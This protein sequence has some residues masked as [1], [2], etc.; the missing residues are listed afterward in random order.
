MSDVL[1]PHPV[2]IHPPVLARWERSPSGVAY[3]QERDSG[4]D[5]PQVLLTAL[6]HGNEFAG[7]I[8]LDEWLAR[9]SQ[10]RRG[11]ITVAFCNVAAFGRFDAAAPDASRFTDEDFNRVW[12]PERLDGPGQSAELR[13]ARELRP[14]VERCTHLLDLHSMHEPC[15]PLLVTG[16]RPRDI[17]FARALGCQGQIVID[18]GHADGV[19]MRDYEGQ[20]AHGN[21]R[22]A[23]LLEAG[24]HWAATSV[25]H[26]R[27]VLMRFLLAAGAIDPSDVV[28]G[29]L[30]PAAHETLAVRVTHRVVAQSK[31]FVFLDDFTGGEV[32][33]RAG[34]AIALDGGTP[35]RTPYDDCVLVMPSLRQLRP[36][37][38]T[39]RL[40]R[41][42]AG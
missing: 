42:S 15:H 26:S 7:A 2:H 14:F 36:G 28:P 22:I 37:V 10:P 4:V 19:R 8:V 5:G 11:R 13:R 34:T 16:M 27:D 20:A 9:G 40:G 3:G 23:L 21:T 29:W 25:A 24:Q 41:L 38:T 18:E 30:L 1:A 35:V 6:V 31:D 17:A 12:A 39:V 33:S 32:I